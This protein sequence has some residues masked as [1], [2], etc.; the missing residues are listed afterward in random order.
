MTTP[1][2]PPWHSRADNE[3]AFGIDRFGNT[4]LMSAGWTTLT[5]WPAADAVG[6][7]F[8]DFIHPADRP[9][10]LEALQ[11]LTRGE[12]YSCRIPARC[13]RRDG[14]HCW[15]EIYA[16]P[17][18][19]PEGRID[20]VRAT[21]SDIT[22]R[23]KEMRALR[24]SEARFRAIAE[25]SPLGV[26]VTD[27]GGE[28]IFANANFEQICGLRAD[29]LLGTGYLAPVPA[30]Y[31]ARLLEA[32]ESARSTLTPFRAEH[33]YVHRDGA[34]IW[35]RVN[36]APIRDG[37]AFLGFVH[38][39]EDITSQRVA[40]EALRRSQERLQLALEGSGYALLDWDVRTGELYLSEQWGRMIGGPHGAAV[41]TVRDLVELIHPEEQG[42]VQRALDEALRAE[43]PYLRVQSRVRTQAGEWK[44]VETHARIM[45]RSPS[46]KALRVT[47]T[48]ADITERKNFEA[49]Q[50]E[51]MATV[52]HELRTPLASVLAALEILNENFREQ[53]PEEARRVLDMGLRCGHQL[54]SL[55]N[56][57][58]DLERIETGLHGFDFAA[59]RAGDLLARAAEAN[60]TYAAR[61]AVAL[62]VEP[63]PGEVCVW[64]DPVP[65]L[66][67]LTNFISNAVKFSA[68]GQA[69]TLGCE[70]KPQCVRLF[71]ADH[72][73][74]IPESS[75]ERIFHR[76][77][78][79]S[80]QQHSRVPGSGLGLSI[81]KALATRLG[82]DVGYC[83]QPG[84]GCVFW[85]E[86]PRAR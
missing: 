62:R 16:H 27:A 56:S 72:G 70:C 46:G 15:V 57:V 43:R 14:L 49:R 78:Q 20:G 3:I 10:L 25:A 42:A 37:S 6:R 74:G 34:E 67:I 59:T 30:H 61:L 23:R 40:D 28:C 32:R 45:E 44:W 60:Q 2:L 53:L 21:L 33:T 17:T 85:V 13:A 80:N 65:T 22:N 68:E 86:L 48:C 36:G 35:A 18:L 76:F 52:S 77:G 39:V 19:D 31:R 83:S 69:V 63:P 73:P 9:A 7:A 1:E 26:Y 38:V 24:E 29:Q 82:G 79:A 11:S 50:A 4:T 5:G 81:C 51:F 75:R 55:I 71:V 8:A 64:T 66:Q 54:T 41:T 12:I 58:L 84:R 47:G